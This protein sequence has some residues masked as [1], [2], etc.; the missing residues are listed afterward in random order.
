MSDP[1]TLDPSKSDASQPNVLEQTSDQAS[2]STSAPQTESEDTS[3]TEAV[4]PT[5]HEPSAVPTSQGGAKRSVGLALTVAWL[6]LLGVVGFAGYTGWQQLEAVKAAVAAQQAQISA[7]A[8]KIQA[9]EASLDSALQSEQKMA[10]QLQAAMASLQQKTEDLLKKHNTTL[11]QMGA[12]LDG[13]QKR[14]NTLSTTSREDWL[15]A[16][17]E[18]LLRLANQRV[19]L[20]H[21]PQNAIA[22]LGTADRLIKDVAD[23]LGDS[24]L[25]AIRQSLG[26]E[27]TALKLVTDVDTEG[28]Y[29]QLGALAEA[30]V[31]LPRLPSH[32][33]RDAERVD[34]MP[35]PD[36]D[37]DGESL[38]K[39]LKDSLGFLDQYV[40]ITEF[41][42]DITPVLSDDEAGLM[43]A[44]VQLLIQQA[45]LALLKEEPEL[46]ALSLKTLEQTVTERFVLSPLRTQF[47]AEVTRFNAVSIAPE[48]PDISNSLKLLNAYIKKL[49]KMDG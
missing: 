35:V 45:Q 39:M 25:F 36:S 18:Y 38:W 1:S 41:N 6:V 12:R 31:K 23:G 43:V 28:T 29:L 22:L 30:V 16:E 37:T 7:K 9:L 15:L 13:Q 8:G 44:N 10:S 20:E 42:G 32:G 19:L 27:M 33:L 17:A 34:V 24:E 5:A 21:N 46:Y 47:L 26:R 48:L 11:V 40:R 14:I 2:E 4:K 3:G 49:H